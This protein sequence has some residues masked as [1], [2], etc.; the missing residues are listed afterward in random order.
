MD[1]FDRRILAE[2]QADGR[3]S[4]TDL[5]ARVGLSLSPCHRRVR[6]LELNGVIQQYRA[7]IDPGSVG[8]G[9]SAIVFVTLRES[10]HDS[11]AA[12]ETALLTV[13]QVVQAER[14]FGDPD[15]MLHVLTRDLSSFQQ[16]YDEQLS[17]LPLVLRLRTTL[18][19][20]KLIQNRPVPI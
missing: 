3:I 17:A 11:I 12:F 2:L 14:L 18:V 15:Y 1:E 9:F 10:S 5:A 8:L 13:P 16:L 7:H 20:K 6:A 4:L 19:M